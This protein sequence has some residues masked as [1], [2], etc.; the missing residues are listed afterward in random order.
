MNYKLASTL[1]GLSILGTAIGIL[2]LVILS[3][4]WVLISFILVIV[5]FVVLG[6]AY[7]IG[8]FGY[9]E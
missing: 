6:I 2:F 7:L 5:T 3:P 4:T 1:R 8:S 9:E